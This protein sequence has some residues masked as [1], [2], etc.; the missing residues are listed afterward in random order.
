MPYGYSITRDPKKEVPFEEL[1]K[2]G[3][4][5]VAQ[6]TA[7]LDNPGACYSIGPLDICFTVDVTAEEIDLTVKFAGA[8]IGTAVL[9]LAHPSF[10]IGG[11]AAIVRANVTVTADFK[12]KQLDSSGSYG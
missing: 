3:H 9:N 5:Q 4:Y 2:I 7:V 10:T 6:D 8:S 11:S 12:A 1:E